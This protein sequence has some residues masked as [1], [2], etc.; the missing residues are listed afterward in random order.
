HTV[1]FY[2]AGTAVRRSGEPQT[3]TPSFVLPL[4]D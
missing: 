4:N 3:L 2:A 1:E